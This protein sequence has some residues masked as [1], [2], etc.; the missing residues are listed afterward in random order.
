MQNPVLN[1]KAEKPRD[2]IQSFYPELIESLNKKG[3][4]HCLLRDTDLHAPDLDELDLLV[5]PEHRAEFEAALCEL[6]FAP[7][8][9]GIPRKEVFACFEEGKLRLLDVH[10]AFIQDGIV[11]MPL[12]D[13]YERLKETPEGYKTLSAE[14]QLLHLFYHNLIG[15][16]HLQPKHLPLIKQLSAASIDPNYL[17]RRIPNASIGKVFERF[18]RDPLSFANDRKMAAREAKKI[19]RALILRSPANWFRSFYNRSLKQLFH[20]RRGVHFAFMGVDG[21]GK[22]TVIKAVQKQLQEAG[23]IKFYNVYMG[24]WGEIRSP[25]MRAFRKAKMG[26]R[27]EDWSFILR[28]KLKGQEKKHS[29]FTIMSKL[30]SSTLQGWFYYIFLYSE[31]WHRYF[32]DVR[33]KLKKGGIVLSDRYIYDLRYIYKDRPMKQ[34]NFMRR[35]VCRFYPSPNRIVYLHNTAEIIRS[36]KPQLGADEIR[37]FQGFYQKALANYPVMDIKTDQPPEVLAQRIVKSIMSYYLGNG[38]NHS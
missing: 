10:Y 20:R 36:R 29:Y 13:V 24:P 23:K 19:R 34:F 22:S 11:Y 27:R 38:S 30:I 14:D 16:K 12:A 1:M 17:K 25:L 7:R 33:P 32:R 8:D 26:I 28:Q 37:Q 5:W 18:L 15:K 3:I 2:D 6:N 35:L 9:L 4:R 31:F 21:A